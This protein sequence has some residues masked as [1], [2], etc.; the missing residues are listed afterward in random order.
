MKPSFGPWT[1]A[2]HAGPDTRLSAFWKRRLS[3]LHVLRNSRPG[4]RWR[5]G[6]SLFLFGGLVLALPTLGLTRAA[7]QDRKP[8]APKGT[9]Q[10][11]KALERLAALETQLGRLLDEVK[12]L[13]RELQ[14]KDMPA[15]NTGELK[16]FQL[17]HADAGSAARI[18]RDLL[19][20][21]TPALRIVSEPQTNSVLV[22]AR[23]ATLEVIDAVLARI[24]VPT[25]GKRDGGK[26]QKPPAQ[27]SGSVDDAKRRATRAEADVAHA[28]EYVTWSERMAK[29][30][31]M[32]NSE[33]RTF[34]ARLEAAE[35]A[36]AQ[37]KKELQALTGQPGK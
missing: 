35:T 23:P 12:A 6:L 9:E 37:A 16:V 25:G 31:Y 34:Q 24:D 19:G 29:K 20:T 33:V 18:L 13:R 10:R 36:L 11:Q 22:V 17:R 30:G 7:A 5:Q 8:A 4:L 32:S 26:G 21:N 15:P 27:P 2:M 1:T 14:G 28:R 3:M